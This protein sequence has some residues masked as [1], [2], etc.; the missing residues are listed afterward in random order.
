MNGD[1]SSEQGLVNCIHLT[2][3]LVSES[4]LVQRFATNYRTSVTFGLASES[5]LVQRF[6][7]NY[8]TSVT[9]GFASESALVYCF[10]ENFSN[11]DLLVQI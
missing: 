10:A 2:F 8:R 5:A 1:C 11:Q 9:F 6:A 7:A 4:A 3:G